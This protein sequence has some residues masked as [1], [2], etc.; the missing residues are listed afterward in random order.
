MCTP[1]SQFNLT[2]FNS[3]SYHLNS[4]QLISSHSN[5][6]QFTPTSPNSSQ[7]MPA[8][9]RSH[10]NSPR[11]FSTHPNSHQ[12]IQTLIPAHPD[13]SQLIPSHLKSPQL[14]QTLISTHPK[15]ILT[16]S[17]YPSSCAVPAGVPTLRTHHKYPKNPESKSGRRHALSAD[18]L[19]VPAEPSSG[20]LL[21]PLPLN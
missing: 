20:P 3:P 13:F 10:P 9:P 7:L 12:L 16:H 8:H 2:H 21:P 1:L 19:N 15:L 11:L 6:S 17:V 14:I 5:S 4:P 18:I